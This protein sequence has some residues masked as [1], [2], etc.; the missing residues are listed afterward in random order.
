MSFTLGLLK[1]TKL[2]L[3][4][5]RKVNKIEGERIYATGKGE[6]VRN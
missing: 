1:N 5:I 4:G 6:K 3:N 2:C